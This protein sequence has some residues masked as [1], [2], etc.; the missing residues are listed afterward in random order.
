[1][2]DR[3]DLLESFPHVRVLCKTIVAYLALLGAIQVLGG[4]WAP[5]E[6][7]RQQVYAHVWAAPLLLTGFYVISLV[8]ECVIRVSRS[9]LERLRSDPQE[10][11]RRATV[12]AARKQNV[13]NKQRR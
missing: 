9:N 2:S 11:R 6:A 10:P 5:A 7:L 1:M 3:T 4:W 12:K 13:R 8:Y